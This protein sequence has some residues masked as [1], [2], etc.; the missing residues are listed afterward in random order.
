LVAALAAAAPVALVVRRAHAMSIAALAGPHAPA[1]T[2]RALADVVLPSELGPAGIDTVVDGFRRWIDGYR[3]HAEVTHDYGTSRLRFTGP[4]PA[5]RWTAQLDAL[6]AEA[7]KR[8]AASFAALS[9]A[10]REAIVRSGLAGERLDR[11]PGVGDARHVAVAL[12]AFFYD[13]AAA[14]DLCYGAVIAR[15]SCRPLERSPQRPVPLR[16]S[17]R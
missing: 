4:T 12:V 11:L 15:R 8:H 9:P 17:G 16:R 13:S 5:T 6:D 3:E 14:T 7:R 2:L 10:R 1:R